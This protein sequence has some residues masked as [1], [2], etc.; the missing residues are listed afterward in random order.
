[1]PRKYTHSK[2]AKE[3]VGWWIER[4]KEFGDLCKSVEP[5]QIQSRE[6]ESSMYRD[7]RRGAFPAVLPG[8]RPGAVNQ[9]VEQ[10]NWNLV[11]RVCDRSQ[12]ACF[13]DSPESTFPRDRPGEAP[14]AESIERL[15]GRMTEAARLPDK[16]RDG[17]PNTYTDGSFLIYVGLP[18]TPSRRAV[19]VAAQGAGAAVEAG[20]Q[21]VPAEPVPGQDH[22]T[23]REASEAI[24]SDPEEIAASTPE[25]TQGLS[26]TAAAH[27][28][29]E[30]DEQEDMDEWDH[31]R[32]RP[33][34]ERLTVGTQCA[35]S[36]WTPDVEEGRWIGKRIV[37]EP[38]AAKDHKA[39]RKAWRE[40]LIPQ[41]V[42]TTSDDAASAMSDSGSEQ[43]RDSLKVVVWE[44]WDRLYQCRHYVSEGNDEYGEFDE[45]NPYVKRKDA[46]KGAIRGFFP[47]VQFAPWLDG[48]DIPMRSLGMPG[49][50]RGWAQQIKIIKLDSYNLNAIKRASVDV[51]AVD[52][53]AGDA[54]KNAIASGIPGAVAPITLS[55]NV[56][57]IRDLFAAFEFK[58]P[59]ADLSA[60][61][62][63]AIAEFCAAYDFP[64][65]EL[66]SQ[67]VADTL[68]QEELAMASG[69]RA[70]GAFVRYMEGRYARVLDITW[71]L[72]R[73]CV[74]PEDVV[75]WMGADFQAQFD[76]WQESPLED[77][78]FRVKF[79][80]GSRDDSLKKAEVILQFVD[81]V[82]GIVD[83]LGVQKYD[84]DGLIQEAARKVGLGG[85]APNPNYEQEVM[86]ARVATLG[87]ALSGP[88][89][90]GQ[91][92]SPGAQK[93]EKQPQAQAA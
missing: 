65:S 2:K 91:G 82:Q 34:Y 68:G 90:R 19:Q 35:W 30:E 70:L 21:G 72:V 63:H 13:D 55:G 93:S 67:P 4:I 64:I 32:G 49:F 78:Q 92:G 89:G 11:A 87:K 44:I 25:E 69:R 58:P 7:A 9:R 33:Y 6:S 74:P 61:K 26:E 71:D 85:I 29:A 77:E 66:T 51:Y 41:R 60:E 28:Q 27:A 18:Y 54:V 15:I 45:S 47:F 17:V 83:P 40:K 38:E 3:P 73:E 20:R 31:E 23:I 62:Q 12:S 43:A 80:E 59:L 76:K 50:R 42:A 88:K 5:G 48:E 81:R 39:W 56:R 10:V 46:E 1:M 86:S 57:S 22:K 52:S 36:A 84:L 8:T 75:A 79:G 16:V 53:T 24:A 14:L 37:M